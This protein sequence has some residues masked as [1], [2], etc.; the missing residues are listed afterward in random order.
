[1]PAGRF[2]LRRIDL[3]GVGGDASLLAAI[4][5]PRLRPVMRRRVTPSFGTIIAVR[6]FGFSATRSLSCINA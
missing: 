2:G 1:M 5:G 6:R 4:V 3:D